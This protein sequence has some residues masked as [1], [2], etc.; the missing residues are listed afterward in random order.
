MLYFSDLRCCV[1]PT[2]HLHTEF[3]TFSRSK[4]RI[5]HHPFSRYY[6]TVMASISMSMSADN[7]TFIQEVVF[8]RPWKL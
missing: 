4:I 5:R 2:M 1:F 8:F 6:S 3:Q 7:Q